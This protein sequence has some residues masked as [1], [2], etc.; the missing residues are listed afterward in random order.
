MEAAVE[1]ERNN[2]HQSKKSR[3]EASSKKDG[4]TSSESMGLVAGEKKKKKRNAVVEVHCLDADA[5][6]LTAA[7]HNVT[8]A[9]AAFVDNT[10]AA[11]GGGDFSSS[12]SSSSSSSPASSPASSPSVDC[13]FHLVDGFGALNKSQPQAGGRSSGSDDDEENFLLFD[14]IISNPPYHRGLN[15]DFSVM[16]ELG[17]GAAGVV[18]TSSGGGGDKKR[19]RLKPGGSLWIV[20]QSYVPVGALLEGLL[21]A[22]GGVVKGRPHSSAFAKVDLWNSDG[23]FAVWRAVAH[24][25]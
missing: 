8:A 17:K 3:K 15:D 4:K 18:G 21:P 6:A 25:T 20:A 1:G 7:R 23:R 5:F 2:R 19:P 12:C 11:H 16:C 10:A 9:V 24:H 14:W 13:F 22:G